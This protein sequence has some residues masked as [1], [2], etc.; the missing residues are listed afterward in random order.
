MA[1]PKS[2]KVVVKQSTK[3]N[4]FTKDTMLN[5]MSA[6][7]DNNFNVT[8]ACEQAQVARPT[9]YYNLNYN[10]EFKELF[11]RSKEFVSNVIRDAFLEGITHPDLILRYKYLSILP[12][13]VKLQA[14]GFEDNSTNITFKLD[15]NQIELG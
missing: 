2:T 11:I 5:F 6:L 4:V 12:D 8:K 13:A 10:K 7:V 15:K 3:K 9:Y 1:R 14:L